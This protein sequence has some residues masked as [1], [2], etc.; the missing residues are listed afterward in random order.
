MYSIWTSRVISST[1]KSQKQQSKNG[2]SKPLAFPEK[3]AQDRLLFSSHHG[4]LWLFISSH[5]S[6]QHHNSKSAKD[7]RNLLHISI[8]IYLKINQ[9]SKK[10]KEKSRMSTTTSLRRASWM[11]AA[12]VGMVE[13]L[14]DQ[15]FARWNYPIKSLHHHV[16]NNL[17]SFSQS[18]KLSS[19]AVEMVSSSRARQ[20]KSKQSEESLRKV[21]YL[22]CWG[23]N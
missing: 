20:E 23:P 8:P 12:S 21:M 10:L 6:V 1:Q 4:F 3:P 13:A 16:K 7:N 11:A 2:L 17:R 15:G 5:S 18:R 9:K 22:S 14:K 19:P